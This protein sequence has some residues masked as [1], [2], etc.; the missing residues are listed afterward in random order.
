[1]TVSNRL[2]HVPPHCIYRA[3][4]EGEGMGTESNRRNGL[5]HVPTCSTWPPPWLAAL[6][7][8]TQPAP[9]NTPLLPEP[10]ADSEDH[11]DAWEH[12]A[13][14]L[15]FPDAPVAGDGPYRARVL[16][17]RPDPTDIGHAPVCV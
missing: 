8:T 9:E 13:D 3:A 11:G 7:R 1:M 5:E 12:P 17:R 14:R 4:G 10:D 2:E 15:P 6:D 16:P